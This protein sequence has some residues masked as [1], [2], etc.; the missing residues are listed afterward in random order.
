MKNSEMVNEFIQT[1]ELSHEV[2]IQW[3]QDPEVA[4]YFF[5]EEWAILLSYNQEVSILETLA[6]ESV[7]L[8]QQL[9]FLEGYDKT[10][11]GEAIL[12]G[13]IQDYKLPKDL[14]LLVEKVVKEFYPEYYW[15]LEV[16]AFLLQHYPEIVLKEL[17]HL[18]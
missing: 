7:H 2:F 8:I 9:G 14:T 12:F 3:C 1:L 15:E 17:K 13:S 18:S 6:H 11:Q 10:K 5:P 16:P 4:G